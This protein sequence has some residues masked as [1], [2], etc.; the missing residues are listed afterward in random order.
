VEQ[1]SFAFIVVKD[2]WEMMFEE[3]RRSCLSDMKTF[4]ILPCAS[5]L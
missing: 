3:E 2:G 1:S 5:P 4:L